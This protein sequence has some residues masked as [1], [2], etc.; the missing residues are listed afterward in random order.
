MSLFVSSMQLA[1]THIKDN[2]ND[3]HQ[4]T[5]RDPA[6]LTTSEEGNQLMDDKEKT[7]TN[8]NDAQPSVESETSG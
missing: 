1:D 6:P 2:D 3:D 8:A 7:E 4:A 5:H